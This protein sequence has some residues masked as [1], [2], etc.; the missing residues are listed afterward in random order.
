LAKHAIPL[1]CPVIFL[2][3]TVHAPVA[4][5]AQTKRFAVAKKEFFRNILRGVQAHLLLVKSP[6]EQPVTNRNTRERSP[7]RQ[8]RNRSGQFCQSAD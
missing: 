7:S 8:N 1:H 3:A 6:E 2:A 5:R 4:S